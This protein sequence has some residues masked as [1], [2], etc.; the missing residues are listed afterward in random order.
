MVEKKGLKYENKEDYGPFYGFEPVCLAPFEPKLI[1][2]SLFNN[3]QIDWLNWYNRLT[4]ERVGA[5]LKAQG[6]TK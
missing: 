2:F 1:D 4:R 5:E 3:E 6:K